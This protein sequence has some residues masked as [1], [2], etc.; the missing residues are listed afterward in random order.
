MSDTN[1]HIFHPATPAEARAAILTPEGGRTPEQR[2]VE[3]TGWLR[4]AIAPHLPTAGHA[5]LLDYGCGIGRMIS[6]LDFVTDASWWAVDSSID[7]LSLGVRN[8]GHSCD[9]RWAT[10]LSFFATVRSTANQFLDGAIAIW[11]L[12]HIPQVE[13][14]LNT[15]RSALKPGAPF[16]VLNTDRRWLARGPAEPWYDDGVDVWGLLEERFTRVVD[17]SL[18]DAPIVSDGRQFRVYSRPY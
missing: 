1:V 13:K 8:I 17:I 3:E 14:A 5:T 4:K 7:M 6:A 18:A 10:P 12:Q 16:V 15:I 2:W 9:V 11:A